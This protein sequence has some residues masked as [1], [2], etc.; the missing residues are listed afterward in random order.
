[1]ALWWQGCAL[2]S[3]PSVRAFLLLLIMSSEVWCFSALDLYQCMRVASHLEMEMMSSTPLAYVVFSVHAS[4]LIVYTFLSQFAHILTT[5]LTFTM[6]Q[7]PRKK[8]SVLSDHV[9]AQFHR[10]SVGLVYPQFSAACARKTSC[11][12][13][14]YRLRGIR[15]H[16]ETSDTLEYLCAN[17]CAT[18]IT[19]YQAEHRS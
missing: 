1:M 9:C 11:C 4:S 8:V 3:L 14:E 2:L 5:H 18:A 10:L 16:T 12:W 19:I 17:Q 6:A 13:K 7:S 15:C